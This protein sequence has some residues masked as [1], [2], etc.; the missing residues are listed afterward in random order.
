MPNPKVFLT[1]GG[2]FGTDESTCLDQSLAIIGFSEVPSLEG[3]DSIEGIQQIVR[4]A[5]P[6]SKSNTITNYTGQLG[7]FVLSIQ[8]CDLVVMPR[9]STPYVAIGRVTGQYGYRDINGALRH[10]RPVEWVRPE[11]PRTDFSQ[12]LLYSFGAF[13][14][15]CRIQRND[16]ENRVLTVISGRKDP[17]L[18]EK[19]PI[20]SQ[21]SDLVDA[22]EDVDLSEL[23][24]DQIIALIQR[25]FT[26]HELSR[27]VD[28]VLVAEG[29]FTTLSP[30]GADGG[31]DIFAGRGSLGL[32]SPRLCVQ[33]KSQGTPVDVSVFRSLLGSMNAFRAEQALL[34]CWGGFT[35]AVYSEARAAHFS[36]RL[37]SSRDLLHAIYRTYERLGKEI[38]AELPLKKVW[39]LVREENDD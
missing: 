2:R 17:V 36:V 28:A 7:A 25:K 20:I 24:D 33:V 4:L 13:M 31:V 16:A 32:D 38:Q 35:R 5:H 6:N 29:W 30:P 27:L 39:M 22:S 10:S 18:T 26:G 3:C 9:K 1:R 34:V 14:T 37:W 19:P 15:V 11:V 12:D 8:P 21:P 23:A